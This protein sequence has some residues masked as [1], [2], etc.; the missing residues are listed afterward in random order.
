MLDLGCGTGRA[1]AVLV[2]RYGAAVVGIDPSE[3]ML[4]VVRGERR[5]PA[6]FPDAA[7]HSRHT[8]PPI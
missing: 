4:V 2:R 7:P 6:F 3:E 1:A 5:V 8:A